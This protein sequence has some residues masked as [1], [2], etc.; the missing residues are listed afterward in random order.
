MSISLV[1]VSRPRSLPVI[2]GEAEGRRSV[3]QS[4]LVSY[5]IR[6]SI[7][8]I[9]KKKGKLVM[10][11]VASR[12]DGR[13]KTFLSV[14]VVAADGTDCYFLSLHL[15]LF[16]SRLFPLFCALLSQNLRR[17]HP[18]RWMSD[19]DIRQLG[20]VPQCQRLRHRPHRHRCDRHLRRRHR[21]N[22]RRNSSSRC[23]TRTTRNRRRW[24]RPQRLR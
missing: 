18:L 23:N 13:E 4:L 6:S 16:P 22:R 2:P 7:F 10:D 17:G 24:R 5:A 14:V 12:S 21:L 1:G 20:L 3:S 9:T 15:S 11:F 19:G 8:W